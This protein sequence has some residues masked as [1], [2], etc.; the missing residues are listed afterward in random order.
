ML[1]E[2]LGRADDM[3]LTGAMGP[4]LAERLIGGRN[5]V[6]MADLEAA[7]AEPDGPRSIAIFY[8]AAHLADFER[9]LLERGHTLERTHWITAIEADP[10]SAGIAPEQAKAFRGF[11]G[12][13]LDSQLRAMEAMRA[14]PED[15]GEAHDGAEDA[16]G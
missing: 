7:L 11:I 10:G 4:E 8:G 6:V 1:V 14:P 16:G 15:A 3:M 13:M 9:R 2:L 5:A 12:G